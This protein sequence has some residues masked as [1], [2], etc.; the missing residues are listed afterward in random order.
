M[1]NKVVKVSFSGTGKIEIL[2]VN[3]LNLLKGMN[4]IVLTDKGEQY[5]TVTSDIINISDKNNFNQSDTIIRVSNKEDDQVNNK[6]LLDAEKA[7]EMSRKF[8]KQLDLKMNILNAAFSFDRTQ[9]MFNFTADDRIDFRELAKKLA[10]VYKTRIEL[11]QIGVRD[12][13]REIG[14]IGPCGR[15]LCC[16]LFLGDFES[17]SINMAKNQYISLKP[18]KINGVCGR[19][20]CCLNYEDDQYTELKKGYPKISSKI[21]FDDKEGK[22]ISYDLFNKKFTIE[23]NDKTYREVE[24]DEYESCK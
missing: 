13:A 18:D 4:V 3:E 14:G 16:N 9:L 12:K 22:V 17:V 10:S 24:L 2:N 20:L 6:N 23:L 11:R 15:F 5:A 7:L 19:L 8:A 21:K 1:E